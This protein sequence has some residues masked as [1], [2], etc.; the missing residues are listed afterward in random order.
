M[1]KKELNTQLQVFN[2]ANDIHDVSVRMIVGDDGCPWFVA[3]DVCHA[4]EISN[5]SQAL[6]RLDDDERMTLIN[7]EGR[8]GSGAQEFNIINESGLYALILTSRK[9]EAKRFKKWVTS[10][11]LPAIRKH[12]KYEQSTTI[13]PN[14]QSEL[15]AVVAYRAGG[16]DNAGKIRMYL[17]SRFNNHFKIASYKQL[18]VARFEEALQYLQSMPLQSAPLALPDHT[19]NHVWLV[20]NSSGQVVESIPMHKSEDIR[21]QVDKYFPDVALLDRSAVIDDMD[22]VAKIMMEATTKL[23]RTLE[24]VITALGT[25]TGATQA[26]ADEFWKQRVS[27]SAQQLRSFG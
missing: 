1:A 11:V 9:V 12:G 14:Q 4:L 22:G 18:P 25:K 5:P 10:E 16:G 6:K 26:E 13:T 17:W 2:F 15:Q 24:P 3:S 8:P 23:R 27:R 21:E 20:I 7:N 19:R